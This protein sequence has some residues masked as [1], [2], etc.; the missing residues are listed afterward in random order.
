MS[1]HIHIYVYTYSYMYVYICIYIYIY[2][3]IHICIMIYIY[4]YILIQQY[5]THRS[6]SPSLPSDTPLFPVTV[7][8]ETYIFPLHRVMKRILDKFI[9]S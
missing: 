9:V 7:T 6:L 2:I 5:T 1:I 8:M 4:I 3:C